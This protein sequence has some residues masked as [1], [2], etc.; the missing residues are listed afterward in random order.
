MIQPAIRP[1]SDR[2]RCRS[3]GVGLHGLQDGEFLSIIQR[4]RKASTEA[5]AETCA[6]IGG[7]DVQVF[8]HDGR[9]PDEQRARHDGVADR[10]FVEKRQLAEETRLSRSRSWPALTPRPSACASSSGIGVDARMTLTARGSRPCSNARANGSVYSSTRS[11]PADAAHANRLRL[12]IDEQAD[13]NAA[14]SQV[15]QQ[16]RRQP[17]GVRTGV[18][19]GLAGDFARHDRHQ[20]ALIR[21][22]SWT[23]SS[24]SGRGSPSML[25]STS[26]PQPASSARD[27]RG[28]RQA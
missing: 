15:A 19:S 18:P 26:R 28:H 14:R 8:A 13:A 16:R 21:P 17:L 12:G 10:H 20:R 23:S 4:R 24:R 25:Y 11:A 3:D 22:T 9:E 1:N 27:A 6:V 5:P 2:R 7:E